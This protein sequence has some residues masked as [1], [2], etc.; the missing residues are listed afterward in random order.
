[1]VSADDESTTF[2]VK[3]VRQDG[4]VL[5]QRGVIVLLRRLTSLTN[6]QLV[7]GWYGHFAGAVGGRN[8]LF[9]SYACVLTVN[10]ISLLGRESISGLF[11]LLISLSTAVFLFSSR[12]NFVGC[13][14]F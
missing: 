8:Q 6:I 10:G 14:F 2:D 3:T 13:P 4:Q 5:L 1:M 11:K 12:S 9:L 7:Q